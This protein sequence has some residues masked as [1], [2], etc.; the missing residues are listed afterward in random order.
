MPQRPTM[1]EKFKERMRRDDE[2]VKAVNE[3]VF[4]TTNIS[5]SREQAELPERITAGPC[6]K[7]GV[8]LVGLNACPY[9]GNEW[10]GTR[11][12]YTRTVSPTPIDTVS[13]E[14]NQDSERDA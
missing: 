13:A 4:M 8:M 10:V 5:A 1:T 2:A 14:G 9:C 12:E 3:G 7:C 6:S 11:G